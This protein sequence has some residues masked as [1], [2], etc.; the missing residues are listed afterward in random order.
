MFFFNRKL[1][2]KLF[3][4]GNDD[5]YIG[6]QND[7]DGLQYDPEQWPPIRPRANLWRLALIPFAKKKFKNRAPYVQF[8]E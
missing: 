4:N 7:P 3:L 5:N 6:R 2:L 8:L 1:I